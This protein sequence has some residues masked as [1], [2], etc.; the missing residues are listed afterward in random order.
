MP[1]ARPSTPPATATSVSGS[2]Q[3][4][5]SPARGAALRLLGSARGRQAAEAGVERS[6][7][8]D[9]QLHSAAGAVGARLASAIA[10]IA[11]CTVLIN[12]WC[13]SFCSFG[14]FPAV[15]NLHPIPSLNM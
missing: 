10:C 2:D 3:S 4:M 11:S 12:L 15:R 8:D 7:G 14:N 13:K 5:S 1:T 9:L 6:A